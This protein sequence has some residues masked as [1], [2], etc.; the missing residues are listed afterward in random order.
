MSK[1]DVAQL[2]IYKEAVKSMERF[3]HDK[4]ARKELDVYDIQIKEMN[5]KGLI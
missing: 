4:E 2:E 5:E 3:L 1:L